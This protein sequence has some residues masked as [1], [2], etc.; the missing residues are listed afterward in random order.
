M[1][2][3]LWRGAQLEGSRAYEVWRLI[4]ATEAGHRLTF[5][6]VYSHVLLT[7]SNFH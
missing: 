7:T 6:F 5:V 2:S 3:R 4:R 1:Y